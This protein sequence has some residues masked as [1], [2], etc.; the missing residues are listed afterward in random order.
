M[1]GR[2]RYVI[3]T[4][5]FLMC[6]CSEDNPTGPSSPDFRY[7]MKAGNEWNYSHSLSLTF[8]LRSGTRP[9][10]LTRSTIRVLVIGEEVIFDSLQCLKL[11]EQLTENENTRTSYHFYQNNADGLYLIAGRG[12]S[13]ALLKNKSD[14]IN[15]INKVSP[16][17]GIAFSSTLFNSKNDSLNLE[18]PAKRALKYPL[19][20]GT[21]WVYSEKNRP[22]RVNKRV[23]GDVD[24][25]TDAGEFKTVKIQWIVDFDGDGEFDD[26]IEYFDYIANEGL[27]KRSFLIKNLPLVDDD[28]GNIGYYSYLDESILSSYKLL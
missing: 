17:A 27:V 12:E 4:L 20:S 5:L 8:D 10:E 9:P 26:N 2:L 11:Q 3:L 14:Y 21:Q 18:K 7:P 28:G 16:G 6:S 22:R 23:I 15:F 25:T 19:Q 1:M 24:V 13:T